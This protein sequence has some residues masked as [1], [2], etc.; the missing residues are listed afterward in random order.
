QKT[1][2]DEHARLSKEIFTA[3]TSR[4][5]RL[6]EDWV[7]PRFND[8]DRDDGQIDQLSARLAG[9][10]TLA[11]IA[12]RPDW[13]DQ[14]QGW[15]DRT[16][17]LEERLSDV[18]HERLTAR[19]VDRRTTAL[20][21][22]LNV[23]S[24]TLAGVADDGEVTVEGEVVGHLEGVHFTPDAGGSALADRALRQAATRAVG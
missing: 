4:R 15:R 8:L 13:M 23:R 1:T 6:T 24:D 2:L 19:F 21:R 17:A 5:G 20:M 9:V 10:R 7:A 22:A 11:Y 18:L 3:L 14:A 16:K 12:N